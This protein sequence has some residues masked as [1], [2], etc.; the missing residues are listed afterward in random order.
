MERVEY[1]LF[2]VDWYFGVRHWEYKEQNESGEYQVATDE[3]GKPKF[4]V[5]DEDLKPGLLVDLYWDTIKVTKMAYAFCKRMCCKG[6]EEVVQ[7]ETEVDCFGYT[8]DYER[9]GVKKDAEKPKKVGEDENITDAL[10][11]G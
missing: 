10:S 11:H 1:K 2:G 8:P 9:S 6:Q 3:N 7:D 5:R 4:K